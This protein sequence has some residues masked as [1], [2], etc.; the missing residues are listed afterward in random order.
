[1]FT[2]KTRRRHIEKVIEDNLDYLVRFAMFRVVDRQAAEDI[3]YDAVL[4]LLESDMAKVKPE[5]ARLYLFRIVRNRCM[6]HLRGQGTQHIDIDSLELADNETDDTD[7][8]EINRINACL[9]RLASREAEVIRM[10]VIDGLSFV[11]I[12]ELLD[13][14]ASTVKSRYKAGMERLKTLYINTK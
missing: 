4:K 13:I 6:S 14:P 3:V 1:M 12:S 5:S 7:L 10:N 11:E 9:E 8:D 2:R